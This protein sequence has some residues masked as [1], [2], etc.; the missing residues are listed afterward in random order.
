MG[1]VMHFLAK[2]IAR[3]NNC[4]QMMPCLQETINLHTSFLFSKCGAFIQRVVTRIY[5]PNIETIW[6]HYALETSTF[7]IRIKLLI[8]NHLI[9]STLPPGNYI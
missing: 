7:C 8:W 5:I 2:G 6:N 1:I 9:P 4:A 3:H